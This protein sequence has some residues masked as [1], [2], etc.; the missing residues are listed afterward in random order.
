MVNYNKNYIPDSLTKK[1]KLLQRTSLDESRKEYKEGRF[2]KRPTI[3]SFKSKPSSHVA[4]ACKLYNITSVNPN[5]ELAKKTQC[6]LDTLHK[7]VK[8]GEG[9]SYSSG[10][11]P[12]QS[13]KAWGLARLASSL[14]GGNA[15]LYDYDLLEK[16]CA[17][18]SIALKLANKLKATK[19]KNKT[20]KK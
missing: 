6:S 18:T 5:E 13:A 7:I 3:K 1:D 4:N 17:S 20:V 11:R 12:N 8:K 14:T 10:S 2:I 16:G 9:A 19:K 15:S